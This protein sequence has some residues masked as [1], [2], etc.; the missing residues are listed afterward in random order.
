MS[1]DSQTTIKLHALSEAARIIAGSTRKLPESMEGIL[2]PLPARTT[3]AVAALPLGDRVEI[4]MVA[5]R[6]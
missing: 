2:Q 6:A 1:P 5:R 4:N 3:V